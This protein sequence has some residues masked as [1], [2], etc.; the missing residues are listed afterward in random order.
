MG[1][2]REIDFLDCEFVF[3]GDG[4]LVDHLRRVRADDVGAEY[5]AVLGVANDLDEAF[6]LARSARA[7]VGGEG[8]LAD[9]VVDLFLLHLRFGHADGRDFRMTVRRVRDVAVVHLVDVLLAGEEL[10]E[11][12]ALALTLVGEHRRTGDVADSVNALHRRLHPL[13]DL[14][15]AAIGELHAELLDAD[16]VDDWGAAGGDEHF[17]DL[18]ILFL[19]GDVDAHGDGILSNLDVAD[20]G[21]GD[22]IDLP[23]LEASRQLGAAVGVLEGQNSGQDFDQRDLGSEGG[24]DIRELAADGAGTDDGHRLRRLLEDQ[25]FV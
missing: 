15:E 18:E 16:V 2:D 19:A 22:D 20:L 24:E 25:R 13:V 3:P 8:E 17:L 21:A 4:Q 9:L 6:G 5:L 23:L 1:V 14:D 11:H 7:A 10:G 12:D